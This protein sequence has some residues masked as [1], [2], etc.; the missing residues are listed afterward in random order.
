[1][2]VMLNRMLATAL[3]RS[4]VRILTV[5]EQNYP[6]RVDPQ[7]LHLDTFGRSTQCCCVA[8][9]GG[10]L[11]RGRISGTERNTAQFVVFSVKGCIVSKA[12]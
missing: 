9:G 2:L 10:F 4:L 12:A 5:L 1:M 8:V 11:I 3:S 7:L 6:Y